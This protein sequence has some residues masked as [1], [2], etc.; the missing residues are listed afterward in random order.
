MADPATS[1]L[2][3]EV[4]GTKADLLRIHDDFDASNR[5]LG[6]ALKFSQLR[7]RYLSEVTD[8]IELGINQGFS[9]R[10]S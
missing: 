9:G 8:F 6:N 7:E 2:G 10:G 1:A 3:P 4:L 5:G